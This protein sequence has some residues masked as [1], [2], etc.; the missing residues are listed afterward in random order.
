MLGERSTR[1]VGAC[2]GG[3]SKAASACDQHT[4][5]LTWLLLLMLMLLQRWR[6]SSLCELQHV[7]K[8]AARCRLHRAHPHQH[9]VTKRVSEPTERQ[10][11]H[12]ELGLGLLSVYLLVLNMVLLVSL[13]ELVQEE[14]ATGCCRDRQQYHF[15]FCV[16]CL[17]HAGQ[18]D[19]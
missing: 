5:S 17:C 12:A 3:V 19:R 14:Q 6:R 11:G 4:R 15:L 16:V 7:W 10:H 9:R 18:R 2:C 8:P 13:I 1:G